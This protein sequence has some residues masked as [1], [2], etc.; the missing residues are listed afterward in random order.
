ME[1]GGTGQEMKDFPKI[2]EELAVLQNTMKWEPGIARIKYLLRRR[3][4][5]LDRGEKSFL[6][7]RLGYFLHFVD[8]LEEAAD[9]YREA[10]VL[11]PYL[12]QQRK[13][14]SDYLM[15]CHYLPHI[16]DAELAERHFAY[17]Q[18]FRTE[19]ELR[20]E[21][22]RHRRHEK[23]RV[24]YISTNFKKHVMSCFMMQLLAIA[25]RDRFEIYCYDIGGAS[26]AAA[27][28]MKS[29][30]NNWRNIAIAE[31]KER[32][33][34]IAEDEIDILFDLS[35][36]T[37][38]GHGL[39]T[40]GYKAAPVQITGIGYMSTS[41]L[42]AVDY[43]LSDHFLDPLGQGNAYFSEKLLRLSHSH[44][45]YTPFEELF[46]STPDWQPHGATVF[47][48]FNNSA[49]I[50]EEILRLWRTILERVPGS[51]LLLKAWKP[52]SL[53]KKALSVG[54]RMEQIEV[55]PMTLDYVHEYMDMDIA[56]DTYPYTGGGTTCEA[57]YMGVPVVTL[58]GTRH[59]TR[60][61][62]SL[63]ENVGLGELAATT[64]EEY[65][66][67][68]VALSEDK[69]LLTALHRNLR[70][71]MQKSPLMDGR[72]YVREVEGMYEKIW[73]EWLE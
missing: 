8:R 6:C 48:C 41:G 4:A 33:A 23:I 28:Q 52:K 51:K 50:S 40:L 44:F 20:H 11:A 53:R 69:E 68:A 61:G 9:A 30:G 59:G 5:E 19:E 46:K 60:F 15:V 66:E 24:G 49:K 1:E 16:G 70:P 37:D 43:C 17:N 38:G 55:R 57:L 34:A 14:Y 26:D 47:G 64:A 65:V 72:S 62:L 27:E 2:A 3:G 54:Y 56:L 13:L 63:L 31:A 29:F 42:K 21:R 73:Q 12:A 25:D 71:M 39:A 35:G 36:H 7:G 45:C 58:A 22:E 10:I 18:F 32:A 67:K